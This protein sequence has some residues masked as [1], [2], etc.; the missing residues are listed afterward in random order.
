MNYGFIRAAAASPEIKLADCDYNANQIVKCMA[1]AAKQHCELLVL[2]E[3]CLTGSTCGDLFHQPRLLDNACRALNRLRDESKSFPALLTFIGAPVAVNG[4]LYNCALALC[5]GELL[6]VVPKTYLYDKRHFAPNVNNTVC[7]IGSLYAPFGADIIFRHKTR[8]NF[9]VAAEIGEDLL[10]A[11]P[12]SCR[13]AMAGATFIASLSASPETAGQAGKRRLTVTRQSAKIHAAYI[14]ANAGNGESTAEHVFSGHSIIAESGCMLVESVLFDNQLIRADVDAGFLAFERMRDTLF[15]T[16]DAAYRV[17]TFE[18]ED[19]DVKLE[20][21]INRLPFV[22]ENYTRR[23]LEVLDMQTAGLMGRL[24]HTAIS[25]VV[26]ALSGGLDS[27][28]ALVVA[29]NAFDRLQVERKNIHAVSMPGFGSSRRTK[30]NA[31]KLAEALGVSFREISITESVLQHF[32]DINH[33]PNNHDLVYENAQARERTQI[34]MDIAA[35]INGLMLGTGGMSELALGFTTYNGDHMSMY[36]VNASLP[37]TLIRPMI[38][39]AAKRVMPE[40][41]AILLDILSTPVSPELLPADPAGQ[42]QETEK[43]VGPYELH[44]FFLYH[45][46]RRG[47]E[48][49]KI[50]YLAEHAFKGTY[51][52]DTIRKW[53]GGFTRRF[54]AGQ[55]KRSC[56]PEGPRIGSVCLSPRGAWQMPGDMAGVDRVL[57]IDSADN[58]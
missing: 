45:M 30:E 9:T 50:V 54:Y 13:H 2:P 20:R 12:P 41:E 23:C 49:E 31:Q 46:L 25:N 56:M 4:K 52:G 3:L 48:P 29:V 18:T 27:A 1:E 32:K 24:K 36:N 43:I 34:A 42:K 19:V 39:T 17:V 38:E 11:I 26:L 21:E 37:K 57:I 15:E 14:H 10:F 53:F 44:D 6:G 28:L 5:R 7:N 8:L 58:R 35:Q 55:F 51:D 40:A 47:A 16:S 22:P 33:D